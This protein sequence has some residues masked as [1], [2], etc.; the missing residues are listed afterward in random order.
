MLLSAIAIAVECHFPRDPVWNPLEGHC[1]QGILVKYCQD[2]ELQQDGDCS[3]SLGATHQCDVVAQPPRDKHI[4]A[5]LHPGPCTL[6]QV[7]NPCVDITSPPVA[8]IDYNA[9]LLNARKPCP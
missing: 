1:V 5:P 9:G 2:T 8:Q 7:T 6:D 3:G 4:Y